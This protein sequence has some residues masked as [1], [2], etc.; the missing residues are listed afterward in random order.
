MKFGRNIVKKKQHKNYQD[1]EKK[2]AINKKNISK[3]CSNLFLILFSYKK[4][5]K[6]RS[7]EIYFILLY[8]FHDAKLDP[9]FS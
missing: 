8:F 3:F 6:K 5:N 2:S 9:N 7:D 4:S 1:E